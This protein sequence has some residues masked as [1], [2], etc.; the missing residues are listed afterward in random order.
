MQVLNLV[1]IYQNL[2]P[3]HGRYLLKAVVCCYGMHY[4]TFARCHE[5]AGDVELWR[6]FDDA[7]IAPLAAGRMLLANV[8]EGLC[9]QLSSHLTA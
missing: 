9:S 8:S 6:Q 3:S 4:V 1:D 2:G 7:C 5:Q